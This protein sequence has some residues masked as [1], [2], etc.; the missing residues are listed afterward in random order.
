[1]ASLC[2]V[3][4]VHPPPSFDTAQNSALALLLQ[5]FSDLLVFRSFYYILI[6]LEFGAFMKMRS[7]WLALL[8]AGSSCLVAG[9]STVTLRIPRNTCPVIL[10]GLPTAGPFSTPIIVTYSTTDS[11]GRTI[12]T[13]ST[14][15]S[16]LNPPGYLSST[17][18]KYSTTD[19]RG[20]TYATSTTSYVP[21]S[22]TS[23]SGGSATTGPA[24]AG[25][26]APCPA[27]IAQPYISN[28]I[29]WQLYCITDFRFLDLPSVNTNTFDACITACNNYS[30]VATVADGKGCIA[31]TWTQFNPNGNNCYLKYDILQVSYGVYTL[32]S[33]KRADFNVRPDVQV[34]VVSSYTVPGASSSTG[35]I[36]PSS[37]S[38]SSTISK[39][40]TG[41]SVVFVPTSTTI[42]SLTTS[43]I[44][45][46][47]TTTA[48]SLATPSSS[49]A[50]V[51]TSTVTYTCAGCLIPTTAT[52]IL[53]P[54]G[55]A[56]PGRFPCPEGNNAIYPIVPAAPF[57]IQCGT[58]Y[59]GNDLT[60][61]N[62]GSFT[63]CL[64]ACLLYVP[65]APDFARC[66][67]VTW[68]NIP[69]PN[70]NNCYLHSDITVVDSSANFAIFDS[71]R[72]KSF[73][74][75]PA[76]SVALNVNAPKPTIL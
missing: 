61:V 67:A 22:L 57:Y 34:S 24:P 52:T 47:P 73:V 7:G 50:G 63:A 44:V 37:V 38:V 17:V 54:I 12:A 45:V 35:I 20:S 75:L 65:I 30:P 1:M 31:V 46:V 62:A 9:I 64:N 18:V 25:P 8:V 36:F 39:L 28:G 6:L 70:G 40:P 14:S 19:S 41:T 4:V 58:T 49:A 11:A 33:A 53:P 66:I 76:L 5:Y 2:S 43:A 51:V 29:E 69:N 23:G 3:H 68:Q 72:L 16:P 15:Y 56:I 32:C 71:A 59:Y 48:S 10:T 60:S 55:T 27:S 13:S 26:S 21:P 74:Y 42:S